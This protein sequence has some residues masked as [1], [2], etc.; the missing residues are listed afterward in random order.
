ML[1]GQEVMSLS[2][3]KEVYNVDIYSGN[4]PFYQGSNSGPLILDEGQLNKFKKRFSNLEELSDI[5]TA[6]GNFT[7]VEDEPKKKKAEPAAAGGKKKK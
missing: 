7:V 3:T 2:G 5:P 1:N 4:H 6:K